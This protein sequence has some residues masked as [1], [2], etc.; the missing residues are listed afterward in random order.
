MSHI[1]GNH[2]LIRKEHTVSSHFNYVS[3]VYIQLF[4][5]YTYFVF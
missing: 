4:K 2:A 1:Y 3:L 5:T